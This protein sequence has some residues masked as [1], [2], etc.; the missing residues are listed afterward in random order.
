[1]DIRI[2]EKQNDYMPF[3]FKSGDIEIVK[4]VERKGYKINKDNVGQCMINALKA[5][6]NAMKMLK[7]IV[8]EKGF[9]PASIS[10]KAKTRLLRKAAMKE[11]LIF[12]TY[13]ERHGLPITAIKIPNKLV[14]LACGGN[15]LSLL[16]YLMQKGFSLNIRNTKRQNPLHVAL[17]DN[18][19]SE[20]SKYLMSLDIANELLQQKDEQGVTPE[21]IINSRR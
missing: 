16:K 18:K 11:N 2:Q 8:E 7:Y 21:S 5:K 20:I 1:K 13:L 14:F 4:Y 17:L 6:N 19:N 15:D 9:S 12:L 10:D 3:A